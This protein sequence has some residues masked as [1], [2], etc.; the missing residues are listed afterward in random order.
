TPAVALFSDG[1]LHSAEL[2]ILVAGFFM[3]ADLRRHD[4]LA[5]QSGWAGFFLGAGGFQLIDGIVDHKIL[6]LHQIRYGVDLL[7][8]DLAWNLSAVAMIL[9]GLWLLRRARKQSRH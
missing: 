5:P 4:R 3:F 7:P 6:R 1:L 9:V 8:Y 2:I